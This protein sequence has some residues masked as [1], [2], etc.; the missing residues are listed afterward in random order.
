VTQ[1]PPTYAPGVPMWVD[2]T[3]PDLP[4]STR[5]YSQLF[6][7][8]GE[9]L[10]EQAGHYTMMRLDGKMVAAVTP[11]MNPQTPSVWTTYFCTTD[12]AASARAVKDAGGQVIMEPFEVMDAGSMAVLADPGG[13]VFC[14]WQAGQHKGAE[15]V[16]TPV[17][18]TWNELATRDLEGAKTFYP[19]V[20]GFGVKANQMPQGGEYVEW[21]VDGRSI[22]G[23]QAMGDMYPPQVPPH[24][25][26]Y[27]AVA[28]CD[29]TV[30]KAQELGAQVRVPCMD[31]PQGRFAILSD[32]Q[33]AT[34]GV[35]RNAR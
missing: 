4:G 34:F 21:Q 23:A 18:F 27:F 31:I 26:V 7:W 11:P 3:S 32:P 6:G 22:A 15:L 10:G 14:V 30:S 20:F 35:I 5:F 25:L 17:S 8:Q 2:L 28:D 13:A 29:A 19:R 9:D 33:G 24:W 1:T 16:N 12:A